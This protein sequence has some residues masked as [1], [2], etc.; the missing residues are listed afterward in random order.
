VI[1]G[2]ARPAVRRELPP[3]MDPPDQTSIGKLFNN[4]WRTEAR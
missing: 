2:L 1:V 4:Y 3:P